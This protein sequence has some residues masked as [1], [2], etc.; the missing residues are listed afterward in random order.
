MT[1]LTKFQ[2]ITEAQVIYEG[3]APDMIG[4]DYND[5]AGMVADRLY[6]ELGAAGCQY[7][8]HE[9]ALEALKHYF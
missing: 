4:F 5:A 2:L 3:I 1:T 6:D 8:Y 9:I 7:D